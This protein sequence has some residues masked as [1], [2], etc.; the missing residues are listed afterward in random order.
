M[1]WL[2]QSCVKYFRIC[3][4]LCSWK[5]ECTAKMLGHIKY[6]IEPSAYVPNTSGLG[7]KM[8]FPLYACYIDNK[9]SFIIVLITK[10]V[11]KLSSRFFKGF[12]VSLR[13]LIKELLREKS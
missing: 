5:N 4:I 3:L 1:L 2:L 11:L 13:S 6:I 7:Y 12:I 10:S 8:I 9:F